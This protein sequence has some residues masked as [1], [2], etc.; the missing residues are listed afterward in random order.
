MNPSNL[1]AGFAIGLLSFIV[2]FLLV[3]TYNAIVALTQR[4][5]KAWANIEVALKQRHDELPNVVAAVRGMMAFEQSVLE[6]VTR[7]RAA[8][9][10]QQSIPEQAVTSEATSAAVRQLFAVV[11]QYPELKSQSNVASL[12]A[13]IQR[14]EGVIADR[15]ELYND[16]VNIYNIQIARLPEAVLARALGY[17]PHTFLEVPEEKKRDVKMDFDA[18]AASRPA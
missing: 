11:E 7:L 5:D 14:L 9:S 15:R 17:R 2:V 6:D 16:S 18:G 12:Q 4:I 8:W 1:A 13:E 3:S 10:P